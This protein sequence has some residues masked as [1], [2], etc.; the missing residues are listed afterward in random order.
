MCVCVVIVL[1]FCVS[2][3]RNRRIWLSLRLSLPVKKNTDA[4]SRDNRYPE[5]LADSSMLTGTH[6]GTLLSGQ[7]VP[8]ELSLLAEDV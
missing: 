2:A 4:S 3:L 7:P 5:S 8:F 1:F 6:G